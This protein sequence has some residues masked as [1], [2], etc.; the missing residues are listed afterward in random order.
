V[1]QNLFPYPKLREV[2]LQN[3]T[4]NFNDY[5]LLPHG[6]ALGLLKYVGIQDMTLFKNIKRL[7]VVSCLVCCMEEGITGTSSYL[8]A[9]RTIHLKNIPSLS[10]L[11]FCHNIYELQLEQIGVQSLEGI[12]NIHHLRIFSFD[13]LKST[14]G[15]ENITGSLII[16]Q[17]RK[18]RCL[19]G[20]KNI[21]IVRIISADD[22]SDFKLGN[23]QELHMIDVPRF[24][25]FFTQFREKKQHSET[26]NSIRHLFM[27][28][29]YNTT[30]KQIW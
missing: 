29:K 14:K 7:T 9:K 30:P 1:L 16:K 18:L 20:V 17:A 3:Q 2:S 22:L 6:K 27:Q 23:H 24:E 28:I 15:L 5:Q 13:S 21:P 26:F 11:R 25:K 8:E 10:N 12:K 4:P 19:Q